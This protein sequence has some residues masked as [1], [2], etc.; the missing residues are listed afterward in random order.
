MGKRR[1]LCS[2]ARESNYR[3]DS[4][5]DVF[6]DEMILMIDIPHMIVYSMSPRSFYAELP[7]GEVEEDV[8]IELGHSGDKLVGP[9]YRSV[10]A[11]T[12][13]FQGR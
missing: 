11:D 6:V 5:I 12:I 8:E 1:D 7:A 3:N 13:R 4:Y 10:A 9:K 2:L